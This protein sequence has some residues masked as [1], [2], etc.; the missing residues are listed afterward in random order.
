MFMSIEDGAAGKRCV[1][2]SQ[3]TGNKPMAVRTWWIDN[4]MAMRIRWTGVNPMVVGTRRLGSNPD[5]GAINFL[6]WSSTKT[7][8][9]DISP[10]T[11]G[12][13]WMDNN[14]R[15]ETTCPYS[16]DLRRAWRIGD[17]LKLP[18]CSRRVLT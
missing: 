15:V 5:T 16:Q 6:Q 3:Q 12:I 18:V 11:A 9:M 14:L 1:P 4:S 8:W 2:T 10:M 13:Q 17:D 7:Q